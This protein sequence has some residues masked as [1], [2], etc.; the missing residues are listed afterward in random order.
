MGIFT[1]TLANRQ[2]KYLRNG[3]YA[4]SCKL[5]YD[6]Y[7]AIVTPDDEIIKETCYEG[8][9]MFGNQDAYD[10]VAEW[11][12]KHLFRIINAPTF[13]KWSLFPVDD[14]DYRSLLEAYADDD[15]LKL[16]SAV[17]AISKKTPLMDEEWKRTLGILIACEDT[18]AKLLS[19]PL[20]I[21]NC[22]RPKRYDQLS[23]S[24]ATQ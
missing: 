4:A 23:I 13:Q 18:N 3:N 8:Y 7:G 2:V 5:P 19:Y 1:W 17:K 22:L 10:L 15:E 14:P 24:L 6:G 16:K 21:V 9:G 20:K 12:R 11:N